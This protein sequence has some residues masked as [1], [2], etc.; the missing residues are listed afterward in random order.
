MEKVKLLFFVLFFTASALAQSRNGTVADAAGKGLPGVTV[1]V[2]GH[3]N[4]SLTDS[5]G[6]YRIE[7][8]ADAVL[9]FSSIGYATREI[10]VGGRSVMD[11]VL[12]TDARNL[13]EVVVTA[14]GIKKEARRLG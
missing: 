5:S 2:A 9:I 6:R 3:R 13:N 7:A 1:Q 12:V 4:S 8:A 14:L 10:R 11:V